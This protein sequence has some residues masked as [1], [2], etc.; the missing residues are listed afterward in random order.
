ML[1]MAT[2]NLM[3]LTCQYLVGLVNNIKLGVEGDGGSDI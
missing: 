1:V 2:N 3:M